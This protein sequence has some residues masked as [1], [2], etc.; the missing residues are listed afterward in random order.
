LQTNITQVSNSC[1]IIQRIVIVAV[2]AGVNWFAKVDI[3]TQILERVTGVDLSKLTVF[4]KPYTVA[5]EQ[6][7]NSKRPVR[8]RE[9]VSRGVGEGSDLLPGNPWWLELPLLKKAVQNT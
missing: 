9:A 8:C 6:P 2:T 7:F 4:E 5:I 1:K 3:C